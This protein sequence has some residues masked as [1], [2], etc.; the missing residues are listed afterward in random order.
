MRTFIS[1]IFFLLLTSILL[2]GCGSGPAANVNANAN[3]ANT[4][5]SNPLETKTPAPNQTVN[6]APTITPVIKAY[7]DAWAKNDEAALRKVYSQDT[8][9]SFEADMKDEKVK[10]LLKFLEDD[11]VAETPCEV[12]NEK[13]TGNTAI[14]EFR[15]DRYPN[16]I[17]LVFVNEN[18]EWKL[19]NKYPNFENMAANSNSAK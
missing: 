11:R 5:S 1:L 16:G 19:T 2:T 13:I 7:C 10:S 8:L 15:A 18:G 4:N 6:N 12:R 14:A 17:Q 3:S 9:K